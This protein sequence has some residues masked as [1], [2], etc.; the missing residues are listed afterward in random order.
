M[1]AIAIRFDNSP[2]LR[3]YKIASMDNYGLCKLPDSAVN[4]IKAQS[5]DGK[6]YNG[7]AEETDLYA[8]AGF[9]KMF[10]MRSRPMP[11]CMKYFGFE[12]NDYITVYIRVIDIL[13]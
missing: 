6:V 4:F 10:W 3:Y 1:K 12:K 11:E 8:S 7:A 5:Y 13:D 2:T 9:E